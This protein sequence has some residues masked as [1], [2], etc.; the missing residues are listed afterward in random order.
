MRYFRF[1]GKI[2]EEPDKH[3]EETLKVLSENV[4]GLQNISGERI[5]I[6]LQKMLSAR[7]GGSLLKTM[8]K[9]GVGKYIGKYNT[10]C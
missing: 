4:E 5:W 3:E 9:V 2:A 10:D 8:L 1:Y 7:F 6:E